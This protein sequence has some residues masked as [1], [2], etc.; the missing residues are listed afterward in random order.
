[1]DVVSGLCFRSHL[2]AVIVAALGV[3]SATASAQLTIGPDATVRK[4]GR[5]YRGIGVNYFDCFLRTLKNGDDTSY[6][7]GFAVLAEKG[8]PFVR[9]CATG[10]WPKDMQLYQSDR[11]EYFRR[12]DGVVH[13]AEKHGIGLIP[14]LFWTVG[15]VPDLVHEPIDQWGNRQSKT[16]EWMREYVREVVTRYRQSPAIWAWEF[17]NEYGLVENLPNASQ[18]REPVHPQLGTAAAR[19]EHD[20]LTVEMVRTAF[21]AFAAEVRKYDPDRLITSG[22]AF[23]RV[24]LWHQWKEGSWTHDTPEQFS[25]MLA[26]EAPDPV[27]LISVHAYGEDDRRIPAAMEVSRRIGKPLFVGEFGAPGE[28]P[29][30]E[31]VCRRLLDAVLAEG[32][33]LAAL[34]VFDLTNQ[35][36]LNI[37]ATNARAWQLDL[38]AA[39][40]RQLREGK[41]TGTARPSSAEATPGR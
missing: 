11:A 19:T 12:L 28:T 10:F 14:S 13:A 4:E 2:W 40:N 7:A 31:K 25:E 5:A 37:T 24:S 33:P 1:M 23:P 8:I 34:W 16:H 27:N 39:V 26:G 17:G 21:A 18:H 20:D 6:D 15:T 35:K 38:I 22:D 36:D 9:F 30:T 41:S 29:E 3:F 32:V